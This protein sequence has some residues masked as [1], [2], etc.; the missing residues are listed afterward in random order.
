MDFFPE[1]TLPMNKIVFWH[2]KNITRL[3][4]PEHVTAAKLLIV[5]FIFSLQS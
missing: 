5:F 4:A 2:S 3:K 1:Y